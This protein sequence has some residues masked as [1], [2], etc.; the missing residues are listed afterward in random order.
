M[1][2]SLSRT[3]I[4]ALA[5]FVP[6]TFL[7][8]PHPIAG[9]VIDLGVALAWL[10]PALLWL[11]V[12]GSPPRRAALLAGLAGWAAHASIL[13]WIYVVTVV[14]GHA[15]PVVGVLAPMGLALYPAL[16]SAAFGLCSAWL[17]RRGRASAWWLAALWTATDHSRSFLLTGFP[18]AVLGYAQH[19]N[20]AMLGLASAAGVHGCSFV[21][22]LGSLGALHTLSALRNRRR[23]PTQAWL[24]IAASLAALAWG[25]WL[26]QQPIANSGTTLRIAALQG[27]IDQGVKWSEAW[28]ERTLEIYEELA[29]RA[30]A[31]GAEVIVWPETAVPG[32]LEHEPALR[33]RLDRLAL[34][35]SALHVVGG[36]GLDPDPNAQGRW[37]FYD[38]AFLIDGAPGPAPRYDKSHLVP[39]GEYVP[40]RGLLGGWLSAVAGGIA[41]QDVSAGPAP[42]ALDLARPRVQRQSTAWQGDPS[43]SVRAGMPICYELLFPDLVRRFALDGANVLLAMTNDAWY[44]RTGAPYQFLAITQLRAAENGLW[45]VRAANTGVSAVID[46]R[47]EVREQTE[48]FEPGMVAADIPLAALDGGLLAT[49]GGRNPGT[50]YTRFGEWLSWSCWA[51]LAVALTLP[52]RRAR[53]AS[54]R[55]G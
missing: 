52:A 19:A 20:P 22:A 18:W 48:I 5:A 2:G 28:V 4:A 8:Y 40:L 47:G 36:V 12:R 30:A 32:A 9:A 29:R 46:P 23:P 44:G 6:V 41:R 15:P 24:A 11:G 17:D 50:F 27:N 53:P 39:F 3:S 35:T 10:P 33:A 21:S 55:E 31:E 43:P 38:S 13:H 25:G 42:R 54:E 45:L 37:R 7:C 16:V 49:S 26:H 51:A 14:Y 1:P 34:E